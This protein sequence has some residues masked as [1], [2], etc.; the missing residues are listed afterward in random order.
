MHFCSSKRALG[1]VT[2]WAGQ[3]KEVAGEEKSD[4]F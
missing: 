1:N 2:A 3:V 4:F